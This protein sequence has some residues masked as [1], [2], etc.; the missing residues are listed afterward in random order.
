MRRTN[1]KVITTRQS[2]QILYGCTIPDYCWNRTVFHDE[3]HWRIFTFHRFS[4]LSWVRLAKR[5]RYIWTEGSEGLPKS[6]PYWKLQPVAYKVNMEWQWELSVWTKKF[7]LMGKNFSLLKQVG[8][9]LEQQRAGN[10][11]N[12][13]R[14]ICAKI[15]CRWFC[16]PIKGHS[17]CQ[18]IHKNYT[19]WGKNLDWCWIRK[20]FTL[21]SS[22]EEIDPSSSSWKP[23]SRQWRSDWIL[24]NK[25]HLQNHFLYCHHWSDEKWNSSMTGGRQKK[26]FQYCSDSSGTI[27][28]LRALQGR[29]GRN[30][31]DPPLQDNVLIP[32]GFPQ[33]HLSRRMCNQFHHQFRIDTGRTKIWATDRQY[34]FCLWIPWT[35][36]QGSWHDRL[37][38]T[39][40]CTIH[41]W[42]MEETSKHGRNIRTRCGSTSTLL[43]RKNWTFDRTLSFC[44]KHFQLIVSRKLF[45]WKPGK[46]IYEK[47]YASLR[48]PPKIS[49]K[50]DWMKDLGSEVARQAEGE[51]AR[52]AKSSQWTQLNPNPNHERTRRPVVCP[53]G[54]APQTRF[55]RDSTKFNLEEETNHHRT[56]QPVV[57][58]DKRNGQKKDLKEW[59]TFLILLIM[60]PQTSNFRIKKLCCMCLKTTKQWSRW[61]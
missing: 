44:T 18:L 58:C 24:V 8:H 28:Y 50:H 22:V 41:A 16:Y 31:I 11:R 38:S 5:G 27:L 13:V 53:Q 61:S 10:L 6:G 37:G 34:S 29:S 60:F 33:L 52:Q 25:N 12:A 40:S 3:R 56:E 47:V 51:V 14:R 15:E 57:N 19:Y 35:K 26:I 32:N 17:N 21:R 48:P 36:T 30:S 42:S 2:E 7:L 23:T 45:G 1:W 59:S 43:W 54:R 46:V 4:G 49:L 39:A 55:S 9:E 20:T